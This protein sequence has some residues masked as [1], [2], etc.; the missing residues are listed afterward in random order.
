MRAVPGAE[1]LVEY[2]WKLPNT[3]K[4]DNMMIWL[5]KRR[6]KRSALREKE[7]CTGQNVPYSTA[8]NE[9][10]PFA[11]DKTLLYSVKN[12]NDHWKE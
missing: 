10:K 11:A 2:R 7:R 12:Q 8:I 9:L 3:Q 6:K 4:R 1:N 5:L